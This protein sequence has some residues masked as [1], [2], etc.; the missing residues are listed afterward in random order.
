MKEYSLEIKWGL[1]FSIM[2]LLWMFIERSVGLH[3]DLIAHHATYTNLIAIPAIAIYVFA[4]LEKRRVYYQ[5][6]MTYW[7]GFKTGLLITLAV[8]ILTPL[9]Q[10]IT[11]S[12]ITP[13]YF[14]NVI[15]Y[16]V[17]N[18]KMTLQ[19]ANDYFN[20]KSYMIQ[21]VL[22]APIM[23]IVTSGIVAAFTVKK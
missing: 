5:G 6:K 9:T 10:W 16:A 12:F 14:E 22:G 23:G 19:E 1:I 11:L 2:M 17:E 13:Q 3:D 8:T 15:A 18:D 7:Q 21:S 20:F 4:L